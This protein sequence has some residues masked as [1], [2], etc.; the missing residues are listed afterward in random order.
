M[1]NGA[2][3]LVTITTMD[4]RSRDMWEQYS[5]AKD[6]MFDYTDIKQLP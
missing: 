2:E 5:L 3:I 6:R 4:I 1:L